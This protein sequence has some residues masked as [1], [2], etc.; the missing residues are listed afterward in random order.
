MELEVWTDLVDRYGAI[1]RVRRMQPAGGVGDKLFPPTYPG[2]GSGNPP[3]RH[4]FEFRRIGSGNAQCVLI[5]SVQ[6]QA[7]RLEEALSQLRT[8]GEIYFP[9][10]AV[11]FS[12][13]S[14][15]ADIG[16]VDT[17]QA[18]HRVFDAIVRD[19]ML[20]GKPFGQSAE[21][22]ALVRARPD[23]ASAI[24]ALSPSA[25]VFGA[26]NSTG[27]GGGLGAKFPR[28][29]VSEIVGIGVAT[30]TDGKPSGQQDNVLAAVST[31]S[32]FA[33]ALRWSSC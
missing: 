8:Q 1:R 30:E 21:G 29:V 27:Q 10:V 26:W 22:E 13:S 16:T 31:R 11:D 32:V 19:A 17:L 14:D 18:P 24:Y 28:A 12:A 3:P 15:L 4:V 23:A 20:N 25:L 9:V 6:S 7:N 5:D 2:E 33:A